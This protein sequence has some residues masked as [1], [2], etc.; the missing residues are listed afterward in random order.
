MTLRLPEA[1]GLDLERFAARQGHKPAQLGA[2][3]M[4]EA[5]RRRKHPLIDLRET[6]AGRVAYAN[7]TRFPVYW[8]ATQIR[9]GQS[10]DAFAKDFDLPVAQVR[11]A[12]AYA[13]AYPEEM[14]TDLDQVEDNLAW[15]KQQDAAWRTGHAPKAS[16]KPKTAGKA[17][18]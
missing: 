4:E 3:F 11:A 12:L 18:R 9:G 8:I 13:E 7:G 14:E 2:W 10:A 1:L 16:A 17:H 6:S 15:V 5:I